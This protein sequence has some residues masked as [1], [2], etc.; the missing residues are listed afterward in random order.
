MVMYYIY[1][2]QMIT[3]PLAGREAM[4]TVQKQVLQFHQM[5][6]IKINK[7]PTIPSVKE[8]ALRIALMEEELGELKAAIRDCDIVAI[9]DGIADLLYVTYGT[10][11]TY[12]IDMETI[13]AEVHRSNMTKI[14]GKKAAGGKWLKPETYDPPNLESLIDDQRGTKEE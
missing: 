6:K 9:A 12:G 10:A 14:G 4:D 8:M 7:K 3:I 13:S 2:L 11:I 1:M 5:F